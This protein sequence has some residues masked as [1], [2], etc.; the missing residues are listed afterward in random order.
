M[1][2]RTCPSL[3]PSMGCDGLQVAIKEVVAGV[4]R[5]YPDPLVPAVSAH[6]IAVDGDTGDAVGWQAGSHRVDGI[7]GAGAHDRNHRDTRPGGGH[8]RL[9]RLLYLRHQRGRREAAPLGGSVH[10]HA[11]VGN[12]SNGDL[13]I[14][15]DS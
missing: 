9:E 2:A 3:W 7:G 15:D 12:V 14:L 8:H 11:F 5:S 10:D 6:V 1:T 13:W 4:E